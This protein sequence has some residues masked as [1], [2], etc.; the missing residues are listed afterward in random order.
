MNA[1]VSALCALL[2]ALSPSATATRARAAARRLFDTH[3]I[4]S[5]NEFN[6]LLALWRANT[7]PAN[8][9]DAPATANQAPAP[10]VRQIRARAASARSRAPWPAAR[11]STHTAP[12]GAP[13]RQPFEK[14]KIWDARPARRSTPYSFRLVIY[15]G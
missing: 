11:S 2:A 8:E 5:L 3:L 13:A 6:H 14:S 15:L 12:P 10:P 7:L 4:E 9:P 1:L